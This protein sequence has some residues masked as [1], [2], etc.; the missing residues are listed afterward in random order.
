MENRDQKPYVYLRKATGILAVILTLSALLLAAR[1]VY[2]DPAPSQNA[3]TSTVPVP[4]EAARS[5]GSAGEYGVG[6]EAPVL[7]LFYDQPFDNERFTVS[8]MLPGDSVTEY[9]CVKAYYRENIEL[10]FNVEITD[11][12]G[13]LGDVLYIRAVELGG[14][15]ILFDEPF[16]DIDGREISTLLSSDSGESTLYYELTAYMDTSVGNA[17]QQT[18]LEA[19]FNWYVKGEDEGNLVP[20]P[21]SS[22]TGD[23]TQ[24][25]FWII[26]ALAAASV[27]AFAVMRKREGREEDGR[28]GIYKSAAAAAVL[29]L[30]LAATTYALV[31][32]TVSV[33]DN[34]LETAAVSLELNDGN[35]IFDGRDMNIE[36]GYTIRRDFTVENKSPVDVYYRL[37][38]ENLSGDLGDVLVFNIYEG[39][40][41]I[42]SGTAAQLSEKTACQGGAPLGAGEE[43]TLTAVV[44]MK[45]DA[46]SF[47]KNSDITFDVTAEGVQVRNNPDG[48]FQ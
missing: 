12:P 21:S 36:P 28:K 10:L 43:R 9:F 48:E 37:Y 29:A 11:D 2:G 26:L 22:K 47:Y 23:D 45:E 3:G 16:A 34:E 32:S 13:N 44:K 25:V 1:L 35:V 17:Y 18:R 42:F 27:A 5:N 40:R 38:L 8:D 30:M 31:L 7:E 15:D 41:I 46:G 4:Q 20:G 39:D 14:G 6:A 33:E 19:D 24:L